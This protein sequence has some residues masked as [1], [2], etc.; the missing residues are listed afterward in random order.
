MELADIAEMRKYNN[1]KEWN[2]WKQT[3]LFV[4]KNV[5]II[6]RLTSWV[7]RILIITMLPKRFRIYIGRPAIVKLNALSVLRNYYHQQLDQR[8]QREKTVSR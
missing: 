5:T 4:Q 7:K 1:C 2:C 3:T 8:I 6:S